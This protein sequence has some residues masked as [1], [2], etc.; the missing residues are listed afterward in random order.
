[1]KTG[2]VVAIK[3]INKDFLSP[4]Q[5]PSIMVSNRF[6]HIRDTE[7]ILPLARTRAVT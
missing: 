7:L 1:M 2:E 5:L 3:Q 4:S 6:L